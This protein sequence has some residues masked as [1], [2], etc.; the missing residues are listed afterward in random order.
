MVVT[1]I[2][3]RNVDANNNKIE[4][5]E[6]RYKKVGNRKYTKCFVRSIKFNKY[7]PLKS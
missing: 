6:N 3:Q 5:V 7:N 4:I 2:F 1:A